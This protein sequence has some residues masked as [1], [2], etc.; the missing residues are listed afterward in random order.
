MIHKLTISLKQHT[1]LIHFQHDQDGATLRASEVKPKLDRFILNKLSSEERAKGLE[2]GWIKKKNEKVWLDYRIKIEKTNVVTW[3]FSRD[4]GRL[5]QN[6]R[7]I[8]EQMPL[9]FGN[10]H[11]RDDVNFVPKKMTFCHTPIK[12]SFFSISDTLIKKITDGLYSFFLLNNFGTRQSKGFGSFMPE[13]SNV[14]EILP[15]SHAKFNWD[16]PNETQFGDWGCF[17]DLFTAIDLFY[18]TLRSGLNQNNVYLK[19]LM[20]FY[21]LDVGEYWDKRTIRYEFRHFTPN[22]END[23]GEQADMKNDG[24]HSKD[25]ARLYR[26]M[27]GL[28]S[29]QTWRKYDNDVITKDHVTDCPNNKIDRFKSP[30]LIKPIYHNGKFDVLLIPSIIPNAYLN[31]DFTISSNN[32]RQSFQMRTPTSFDTDDFLQYITDDNVVEFI[33]GEINEI[34]Y[35]AEQERRSKAKKI[36]KTLLSIFNN[37]K[38]VKK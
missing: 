22:R 5:D 19:S 29:V 16:L 2:E 9:F 26:D 28:S 10:M 18:K 1:P 17:Y 11:R 23:R 35:N 12:I 21:A 14:S 34:L 4:T 13:T 32:R 31:A 36:A 33:V 24:N 30:I 37:I 20:Y 15:C 3:D 27:L 38:Y 7:P 8:I 25:I 6:R